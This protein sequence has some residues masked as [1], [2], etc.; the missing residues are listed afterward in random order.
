MFKLWLLNGAITTPWYVSTPMLQTWEFPVM[1]T[2]ALIVSY[3]LHVADIF[4]LNAVPAQGAVITS[5]SCFVNHLASKHF[6]IQ[7]WLCLLWEGTM[8]FRCNIVDICG[9]CCRCVTRESTFSQEGIDAFQ[10]TS[11]HLRGRGLWLSHSTVLGFSARTR[12]PQLLHLVP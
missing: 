11:E 3:S 5:S 9:I 7:W 2:H 6:L 4:C 8:S 10:I 1:K 12:P